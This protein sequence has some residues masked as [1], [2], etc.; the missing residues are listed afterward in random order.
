MR[1]IRSS[2]RDR[3]GERGIILIAALTL[4]IL[5][6]ALMELLLL[7]SSRALAEARNF[8]GRVVALTLCEN[9]AELAA[10]GMASSLAAN[11]RY[12]NDEGTMSGVLRRVIINDT[13][14]TFELIGDGVTRGLTTHKA[15]VTLRGRI[16]N[17]IVKIEYA[18][19]R[20]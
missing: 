16:E 9:A 13:V 7:D 6:F 17:G 11:E 14:S 2:S 8:R 12:V 18:D 15:R 1:S 20:N 10:Q 3:T 4:A 19:H 5:Y